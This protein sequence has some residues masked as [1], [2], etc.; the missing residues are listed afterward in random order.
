MRELSD[1][2]TSDQMAPLST[3]E[4]RHYLETISQMASENRLSFQN[5]TQSQLDRSQIYSSPSFELTLVKWK[6]GQQSHIHDHQGCIS[7]ILVLD[8]IALETAFRRNGFGFIY[9]VRLRCLM[10]GQII[11]SCNDEI[12]QIA[13]PHEGHLVSLHLHSPPLRTTNVYTLDT[14]HAEKAF[15]VEVWDCAL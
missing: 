11:I 5:Y 15:G 7:G 9:P 1:L 12:H 3:T 2:L 8:G 6:N 14:P 4:V 13:N 10:K